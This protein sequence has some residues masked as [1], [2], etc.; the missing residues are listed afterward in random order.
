MTKTIILTILTVN[1]E[2]FKQQARNAAAFSD[3]L[4]IDVMDGQFVKNTS[5]TER[6]EINKLDLPLKYELHLMVTDPVKEMRTWQNVKNV[7]RVLFPVETQNP[8]ES[9]AFARQA[10]WQVGLTLNPETPLSA[11]EPYLKNVDVIQFMTVHPGQQ[12]APFEKSVLEK[13]KLLAAQDNHPAIAVD[14]GVNP[15]TLMILKEA[16][17]EIFNVGSF[18]TKAPDMMAAYLT[19]NKLL[20]KI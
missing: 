1:F 15:D 18:F 7:F 17:V 14:G 3:Y 5:F 6:A 11:A 2:E 13:I 8:A 9:I 16:G 4:Q 19:L 10:G 20:L 12:G